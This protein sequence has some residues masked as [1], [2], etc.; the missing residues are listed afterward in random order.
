MVDVE[1]AGAQIKSRDQ[2]LGLAASVERGSEHPLGKAIVKEAQSRGLELLEPDEFKAA[3][4]GGVS[5]RVG[6]LDVIVGRPEWIMEQGVNLDNHDFR[7]RELQS[8]GKT[9]MVMGP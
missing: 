7:V 5:A 4:G 8:Q 2:I 9:V 3:G 1:S 6:A